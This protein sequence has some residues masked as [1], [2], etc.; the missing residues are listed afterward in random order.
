MNRW[1][2][3]GAWGVLLTATL[4]LG[5]TALWLWRAEHR[6]LR[7][8]TVATAME[9]AETVA[10][11]LVLG[12][13][14]VQAGLL[15][16][17]RSLPREDLEAHLSDWR[18]R[19]PLVRNV[20]ILS[21]DGSLRLPS[22][23][24]P[25]TAE[26][27]AF[28]RRFQALFAGRVP[29]QEPGSAAES[30]PASDRYA[31]PDGDARRSL[32][33]LSQR[34]MP[35]A[36]ASD[37][38]AG[39]GPAS[40]WKAWIWENRLHLLGWVDRQGLR[41]G[42][43]LEMMALLSR[44]I[45]RIPDPPTGAGTVALI[46]DQ[47]NVVHQRGPAAVGSQTRRLAS[48]QIGRALPHWQVSIYHTASGAAGGGGAV[49]LV[50]ALM[51]AVFM[52]ALVFGG[53]VLLWQAHRYQRDAQQKTTFVSN[54]SHEL[55]TPLTTIRMYAELLAEG[56]VTDAVKRERYLEVMVNESRRLSRLVNNVLDFN[57][58][59]QGR[60]QYR[61][62]DLDLT[63]TVGSILDAQR[64]RIEDAG[65]CLKARLPSGPMR[66]RTDRD[67][68]EQ[69]L[70][71]LLDNAIKYAAEG[72]EVTVELG[73]EGDGALL[74]VSDRGPGIPAGQRERVFRRFHRLDDSL[75]ATHPGSGLGLTIARRVLRGVGGDLQVEPREL[76][77]SRFCIR[78]P[79][80]R[81]DAT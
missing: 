40:G 67:A 65:L 13:A 30:A 60:K 79:V 81:E 51:V 70:L 80:R 59:E 45:E 18:E 21:P 3:A 74:S 16:G 69:A 44:L 33:A 49:A 52:C 9:Y 62:E 53:S 7:T 32:F 25:A 66:I 47:G 57:R 8:A 68:V 15:D 55:K 37:A 17:L 6:Q 36:A 54:V 2:M 12:V 24:Q 11:R 50:G 1:M 5:G 46:D 61:M 34:G 64:L 71:N 39:P 63:D 48:V 10:E 31:S 42:V 23:T 72:G 29:W 19:Q 73:P 77:G 58:L 28:L 75:T 27:A 76:G 43:E 14:E 26:E 20:F 35:T 22:P 38:P 78:L 41:Y 56:R 4:A